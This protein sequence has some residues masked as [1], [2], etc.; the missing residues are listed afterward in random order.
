MWKRSLSE[1]RCCQIERIG[2]AVPASSACTS[3]VQNQMSCPAG[4][5]KARFSRTRYPLSLAATHSVASGV[6]WLAGSPI[7]VACGGRVSLKRGSRDHWTASKRSRDGF[8]RMLRPSGVR[9]WARVRKARSEVRAEAL[10]IVTTSFTHRVSP[11]ESHSETSSSPWEPYRAKCHK[12]SANAL[13]GWPPL[14]NHCLIS[15]E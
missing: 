6:W 12:T 14:H 15:L 11:S 10:G 4:P 9:P 2:R 5:L 7:T 1:S 3:S 13:R 8:H